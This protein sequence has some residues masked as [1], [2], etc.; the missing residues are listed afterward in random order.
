MSPNPSLL[1]AS[2]VAQMLGVHPATVNRWAN[3]G[4]L[5]KIVLPSGR[6]KFRVEDVE[7]ILAG[8]AA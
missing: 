5:E 2:Q 4:I 6:F 8:D 7:K 1:T 3:E